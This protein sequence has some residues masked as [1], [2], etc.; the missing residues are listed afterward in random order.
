M[1]A[2]N[3]IGERY[4]RLVVIAR[5]ENT[6]SGNTRWLCKCDC[7]KEKVVAYRELKNGD[8]KSCGCLREEKTRARS[9][10]PG[11]G[12]TKYPRLYRIWHHMKERCYSVNCK[13]Y[14]W[15]GARGIQICDAWKNSFPEFRDWALSHG[16]EDHLT[17]ERKNN[18][19]NYEP[20]NC[21]WATMKEQ[22]QNRRNSPKNREVV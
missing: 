4:G 8:T 13:E 18:D 2:S 22:C 7:G 1:R 19:G 3:I 16:Y 20:G 17:I 11:G 6:K 21:K 12:K 10:T 14:R 5:A 15:Y 9:T